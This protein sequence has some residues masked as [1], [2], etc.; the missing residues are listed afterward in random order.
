MKVALRVFAYLLGTI[1]TGSVLAWL[2]HDAIDVAYGKVLSRSVLLFAALGLIP[3]WR[4]LQLSATEIQLKPWRRQQ[5]IGSY[6]AGIILVAP[7]MLCFLVTGFRVL[8][9]DFLP[10]SLAFA[11]TLTLALF[12]SVLVALFEECLFRGVGFTALR[13]QRSFAT[14]AGVTSLFYAASHFL[15]QE[16]Q[17]PTSIQWWSGAVVTY[18]ALA[19]VSEMVNDWDSALCLFLLGWVL[20]VVRER[21]SLWV[22]IGLH[23]AWVLAIRVYKELTV[24]DVVNPYR[25]MV[26]D[27][28]HFVGLAAAV[29]L[30]FLWVLLTLWQQH[31]ANLTQAPSSARE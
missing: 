4:G 29:W 8:D 2:L 28:D 10:W 13:R 1:L 3:L 7:L 21:L 6:L 25:D 5:F 30:C 9:P 17:T 18:E 31:Q 20:C 12:G 15:Q 22:C 23:A 26:G 19:G 11:R 27:Y 14:A 16:I 24:R